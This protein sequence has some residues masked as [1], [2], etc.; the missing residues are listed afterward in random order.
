MPHHIILYSYVCVCMYDHCFACIQLNTITYTAF[1]LLRCVCHSV[2]RALLIH[3]QI[4]NT[5]LCK[6]H[7]ILLWNFMR[8]ESFQWGGSFDFFTDMRVVYSRPRHWNRRQ[9]CV[10]LFLWNV[11]GSFS[12]SNWMRCKENFCSF[13]KPHEMAIK[14]C[15]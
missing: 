5:S 3:L 6:T 4:Y 7:Y 1:S 14:V 10:Y 8:G 9:I 15:S 13:I 11:N 2:D 12:I